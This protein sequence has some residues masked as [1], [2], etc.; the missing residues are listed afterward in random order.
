MT[1]YSAVGHWASGVD[2]GGRPRTSADLVRN[3]D[4]A[5]EFGTD[6]VGVTGGRLAEGDKDLESARARVVDGIARA[7]P[8][9][10]AT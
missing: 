3:L 4:E 1:N 8:A 2:Y 10:Q 6:I 5:L 7:D 9:R